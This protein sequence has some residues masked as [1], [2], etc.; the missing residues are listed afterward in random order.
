ME[1]FANSYLSPLWTGMQLLQVLS[2]YASNFDELPTHVL[3]VSSLT[4]ST[5][6]YVP[7]SLASTCMQFC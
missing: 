3:I 7:F 4:S 5:L 1:C 2:L 6:H